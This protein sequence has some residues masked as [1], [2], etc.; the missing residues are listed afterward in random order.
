MTARMYSLVSE[1]SDVQQKYVAGL[2]GQAKIV[3]DE[4]VANRTPRLGEDINKVTGPLFTTRQDTLRVTLYYIIVFKGKGI[5]RATEQTR[6]APAS[7]FAELFDT[8]GNL[9]EVAAE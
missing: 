6:T 1:L 3:Y 2:K 9:V 7:A 8:D 5:V 4:L